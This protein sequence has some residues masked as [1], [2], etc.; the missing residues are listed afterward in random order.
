MAA[1]DEMAQEEPETRM[2][3]S[4]AFGLHFANGFHG[5]DQERVGFIMKP[6]LF[7]HFL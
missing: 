7:R 2:D 5:W 3:M 4:S 1:V 6:K